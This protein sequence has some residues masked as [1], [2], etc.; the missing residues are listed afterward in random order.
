M[1]SIQRVSISMSK[2]ST[3]KMAFLGG[4]LVGVPIG[5]AYYHSDHTLLL[6]L[7]YYAIA[8]MAGFVVALITVFLFAPEKK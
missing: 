6:F 7:K 8:N 3:R 2:N 4:V 5:W 1:Y